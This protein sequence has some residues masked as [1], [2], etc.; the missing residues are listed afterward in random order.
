[1]EIIQLSLKKDW[2]GLTI[3][4]GKTMKQVDPKRI[5]GIKIARGVRRQ[6]K[7]DVAQFKETYQVTPK[8]TAVL[9]GDDPASQTYV[10]T[11]EKT[12][13]RLGMDSEV[14][15]LPADTIEDHLL[16]IV[17]E[18]NEE[19]TNHGILVQLPLPQHIQTDAVIRAIDPDKDVD[20]F[21]PDN[22]VGL[23]QNRDCL[24]P[25][26][27]LGCVTL[28]EE[29]IGNLSGQY[30]VIVGRSDI[31][32]KPLYWELLHRQVTPTTCH[33]KSKPLE[34]YTQEADIVIAATGW[35]NLITVDHVKD[36][37]VVV[38]VGINRVDK[39]DASS[40]LLEWRRKDFD[41]KGYT[42]VGDVDYQAV[43]EKADKITPVPGGVG[44]MTIAMLMQN[45][46]KAASLQV[47]DYKK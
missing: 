1:M 32:G 18:L 24:R 14:I 29:A 22:I 25:C 36:G 2:L 44:P 15:R 11:K 41:T 45:T 40:Q 13:K 19:K 38:D 27:P 20:G 8:L 10:N 6:V 12:C 39:N 21:H 31:V 43:Y 42:L 7:A 35:P 5:S 3:K 46:L 34:R 17:R 16:G 33:S 30:A 23:Q 37:V 28:L 9:V 4:R 26:T 47:S